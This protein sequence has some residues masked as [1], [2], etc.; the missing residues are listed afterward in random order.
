MALFMSNRDVK[1]FGLML[2]RWRVGMEFEI[3]YSVIQLLKKERGVIHLF[4]FFSIL[5]KEFSWRLF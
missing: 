2:M 1:W 4:E 3:I 5:M